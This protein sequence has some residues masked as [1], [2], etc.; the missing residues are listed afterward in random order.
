M[1]TLVQFLA[2]G[3][4]GAESGTATFVLRGTASSAA[5]FLY[6]DFERTAQPGTNIITLDANGAAEVYCSV[7]CDVILKNSAGTTLRTV[8]VGNSSSLVEVRSTSFRGDDYDGSP[9][10]TAG[11]P[12]T[13]TSVLNLWATSAG[14]TDFKVLF[15]GVATNLQTALAG[16]SG[17][18]VNVKDPTYGAVG[19]GV[20][21]DTTAIAAAI[22]AAAGGIVFFPAGTY[23][24][25]QIVIATANINLLGYGATLALTGGGASL[26]S[27]SDNTQSATKRITGFRFTAS[28]SAAQFIDTEDNQ[29]ILIEGCRF[30]TANITGRAIRIRDVSGSKTRIK[31]VSCDFVLSSGTSNAIRSTF[32][33]GVAEVVIDAC[34][35]LIPASFTG[36][37]LQGPDFNVSNCVFDAALVTSGVYRHID[38]EDQNT[39]GVYRGTVTGCRFIDGGSTGFV[40]KLTTLGT[41][42][43]FSEDG[44]T[45]VG[46]TAP[47]ASAAKGQTYEITNAESGSPG[48]IRLGSRKGRTIHLTAASITTFTASMVL[49][50]ENVVFEHSGVLGT[51]ITVPA[52]LPGLSGRIVVFHTPNSTDVSIGFVDSKAYGAALKT[53]TIASNEAYFAVGG[54]DGLGDVRPTSCSY[55][56]TVR[57]DGVFRSLITSEVNH[58]S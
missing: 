7:Y 45:F 30:E 39:A 26:F 12:I 55:F 31:I 57:S 4:K 37:V 13:L 14:T 33:A 28:G 50:A 17:L 46:F 25:D 34:S 5:S 22:T 41:T 54:D 47:T 56:T 43:S 53:T 19:D 16:F 51:T 35:F 27:F 52:L 8:T 23:V 1:A 15:G 11:Q 21:N 42:C 48:L 36:T 29:N 24:V 9:S 18:F 40:F 49:E 44:N 3:V 20:T 10:N 58:W 2:A 6:N 38:A 32:V